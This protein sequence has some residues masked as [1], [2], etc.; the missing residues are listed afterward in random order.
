[1][2]G[3]EGE[4]RGGEGRWHFWHCV[5]SAKKIFFLY[6]N[7]LKFIWTSGILYKLHHS[8]WNIC[9]FSPA[10]EVLLK[11]FS[12]A[13]CTHIFSPTLSC[14]IP[15]WIF[16]AKRLTFILH[17]FDLTWSFF[18][19][20]FKSFSLSHLSGTLQMTSTQWEGVPPCSK[21]LHLLLLIILHKYSPILLLLSLLTKYLKKIILNYPICLHSCST[22][23]MTISEHLLAA[24][25][26]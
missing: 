4:G 20:A 11:F 2:E 19:R 12:W 13:L 16:Q 7:I 9:L 3:R 17:L 24:T 18:I 15:N 1:M 8:N 22:F 5:K 10:S 21:S 14:F 26:H 6:I 25:T 23:T